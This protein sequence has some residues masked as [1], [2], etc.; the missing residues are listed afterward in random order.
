MISRYPVGTMVHTR[1]IA[2]RPEDPIAVVLGPTTSGRYLRAA[3]FGIR[4]NG[5]RYRWV[6]FLYPEDIVGVL[7]SGP[8]QRVPYGR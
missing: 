7:T 5:S 1:N 3:V 2:H 6:C 4:D 8:L